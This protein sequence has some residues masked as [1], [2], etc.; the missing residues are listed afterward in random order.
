MVDKEIR[1]EMLENEENRDMF[2]DAIFKIKKECDISAGLV[3]RLTGCT[4]HN[5]C[6]I[7]D[8]LTDEFEEYLHK[9]LAV[10]KK[11]KKI[12]NEQYERGVELCLKADPSQKD[13]HQAFR[14]FERAVL[15]NH[16]PAMTWLADCFKEGKGTEENEINYLY[17]LQ[18][19]ANNNSKEPENVIAKEQAEREL[20]LYY[21]NRY[22]YDKAHY[23]IEK[24][25]GETHASRKWT[26]EY[27]IDQQIKTKFDTDGLRKIYEKLKIVYEQNES[28]K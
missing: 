7:A 25:A 22:E 18:K 19:A 24:I 8:I 16:Y 15:T 1:L 23:Y 28:C 9:T 10:G 13:Y 2:L 11:M 3:Q 21:V 17:W 6:I 12:A 4:Y 20:V 27:D 14:C 5:A 26:N